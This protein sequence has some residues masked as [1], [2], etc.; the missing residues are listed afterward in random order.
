MDRRQ[1]LLAAQGQVFRIP[2]VDYDGDGDYLVAGEASLP[3]IGGAAKCL[4][5]FWFRIDGDDGATMRIAGGTNGF[6]SMSITRN[7]SNKFN[8]G[9]FIG[10]ESPNEVNMKST[11]SY[12]TDANWHHF[13][14]SWDGSTAHHLYVDGS[15]DLNLVDGTGTTPFYVDQLFAIS[16]VTEW[17][18]GISQFYMTDEYLDLSVLSNR[19]KLYNTTDSTFVDLGDD[20]SSVTGTQPLIYLNSN[21]TDP[22]KNSGSKLDMTV[23]GSPSNTYAPKP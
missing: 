22:G 15:N 14:A 9:W 1:S 19:D 11:S 10:A 3:A 16:T 6:D 20:A 18:G 13:M 21:Y 17:N 4:I 12:T 7:T 8:I 5:S 2:A 23:F